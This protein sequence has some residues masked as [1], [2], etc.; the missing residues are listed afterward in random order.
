MH[1]EPGRNPLVTP[2][3]TNLLVEVTFDSRFPLTSTNNEA[4][5]GQQGQVGPTQTVVLMQH[6]TAITGT[7]PST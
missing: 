3:E 2:S 5:Q 6:R 7:R 4:R 1:P